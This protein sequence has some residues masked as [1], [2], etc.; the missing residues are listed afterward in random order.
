MRTRA[1]AAGDCSGRV[2]LPMI[3]RSL[4]YPKKSDMTVVL[5]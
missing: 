2:V 4:K 5:L 1:F 3:A